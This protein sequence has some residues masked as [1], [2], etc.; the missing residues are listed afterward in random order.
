MKKEKRKILRIEVAIVNTSCFF[1]IDLLPKNVI[2]YLD[3]NTIGLLSNKA[4]NDKNELLSINN[5]TLIIHYY[6]AKP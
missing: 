3:K 4:L 5:H 1:G 6:N 2:R